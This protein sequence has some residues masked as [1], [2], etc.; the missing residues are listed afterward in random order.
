LLVCLV[1][2]VCVLV[3]GDVCFVLVFFSFSRCIFLLVKLEK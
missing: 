1:N 2:S 3:V